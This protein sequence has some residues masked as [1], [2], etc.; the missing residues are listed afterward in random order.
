MFTIPLLAPPNSHDRSRLIVKNL[1]HSLNTNDKLRAHFDDPNLGTITDARIATRSDG[2][3][4]GFGF[5]GYKTPDEASRAKEFFDRTFVDSRRIQVEL[6][7]TNKAR[8]GCSIRP[9]KRPRRD[10]NPDQPVAGPSSP[11]KLA[12]APPP[13]TAPDSTNAPKAKPGDSRKEQQLAKFLELMGTRS[14]TSNVRAW[15]NEEDFGRNEDQILKD[16][17]PVQG[18]D[19]GKVDARPVG[20]MS[21][22]EWMKS[23]MK[24][25]STSL[26]DDDG[27]EKMFH[28]SDDEDGGGGRATDSIDVDYT[29][30]KHDAEEPPFQPEEVELRRTNEQILATGRLFLR[31]LTY[32]CSEDD[33]RDVF[34]KYGEIEQ[35]HIPLD[36]TTHRSKGWTAYIR[37]STPTD[38]LAAYEALDGKD[39][40]GRLVHVLPALDPPTAKPASG[41]AGGEEG[42][43]ARKKSLKE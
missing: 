30:G 2:T 14:A 28:Q 17:M 25:V 24:S 6:V 38:A 34:S 8:E 11:S 15:G 29:H 10:P 23:R 40:Q 16:K 4:R 39:L 35:I 21:D 1:P 27:D 7:E 42:S 43:S 33:L 22:M 41:V 12:A 37:Y 9:V 5:L 13:P 36:S 3:L 26:L 32:S 20:E 18:E 19:G 31:N